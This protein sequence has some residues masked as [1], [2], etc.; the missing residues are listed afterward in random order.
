[1]ITGEKCVEPA[2][3]DEII[4]DRGGHPLQLWGWGE[5]KSHHGWQAHRI[6][7]TDDT[8]TVVG[9]AQILTRKLPIPFRRL[10]YIPRGPVVAQGREV[11]LLDALAAYTKE[12]LPGVALTIEPDLERIDLSAKWHSSRNT[13]LIPNTIVLNLNKTEAELTSAMT[14]KTRQYIRKSARENL[15][16]KLIKDSDTLEKCLEIY[17][18]TAKRA[19]FDIHG[20]DYYLDVAK[21][22]EDSSVIFVAFEDKL[23]VAFLWLAVSS[24]TAFEL[25]GGMN[26]RGQALRANYALKMHAITTCQKW[27]IERYDLNGLLNDGISTFKRGFA[28]HETTLVGTYDYPLGSLYKAWSKGLPAIKKI[29]KMV[30]R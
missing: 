18:D 28:N 26:E 23:P 8:G 16:F 21:F 30:R 20:D 27:R 6:L 17:H 13:I 15:D 1:M 2:L 14:K 25:Y 10:C 5:V 7:F 22:M 29:I 19:G 24:S 3:W 11:E 12:H 4:L 9:A